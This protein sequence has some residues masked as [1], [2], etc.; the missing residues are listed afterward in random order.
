[1]KQFTQ[2]RHYDASQANKVYRTNYA[3]LATDA[4]HHKQAEKITN[5]ATD[6]FKIA[7]MNIDMQNTFCIPG[8]ELFVEGAPQDSVRLAEFIYGNIGRITSIF[9]TMD[10][11]RSMQIFHPSFFVDG[12]EN[13]PDPHT[14]ISSQ[15][16]RDGRWKVNPGIATHYNV[17]YSTISKHVLHY[18]ESLEKKGKYQLTIWPYHAMLGGTGHA[19]VNIIEEAS[20]FHGQV[21][22]TQTGI[23]IKGGNPLTEN[24]S[25]L[26]PEILMGAD[27][28]P[29]AT[30]NTSFVEKLLHYD[31][32]IIAGQAKSHCV[33]WTVDDL[34]NEIASKDPSLASK[35]YILE[36]CTSP[37]VIP[38]VVDFTDQANKAFDRFK[39]AG[40]NIVRSSDPM[41][42]WP[43]IN[44]K[45]LQ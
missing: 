16:I 24:Y 44:T 27:N 23:E 17:S 32:L 6:T 38:N 40:M 29:I 1:M 12:D 8:Y 37:V 22:N 39:A 26:S 14:Q 18:C 21:R 4:Q 10:T 35:V 43:G 41:N 15:D 28:T 7:L 20:F 34:L 25:V 42:T 45:Q 36:D 3:Q 5:A 2:P 30:K 19:L 9:N 13:N 33:A 31:M 11:H